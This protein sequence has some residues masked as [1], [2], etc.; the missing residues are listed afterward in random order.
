MHVNEL[1]LDVDG[2]NDV[3]TSVNWRMQEFVKRYTEN[4]NPI[5]HQKKILFCND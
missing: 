3:K 5:V 1:G 4:K 2:N